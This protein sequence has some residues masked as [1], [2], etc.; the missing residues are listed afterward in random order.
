MIAAPTSL[1]TRGLAGGFLATAPGQ[2]L[3]GLL[4]DHARAR[5]WFRS[6]A[7]PVRGARI[8][9]LIA[10]DGPSLERAAQVVVLLEITYDGGDP[11]RDLYVL[12]LARVDMQAVEALQAEAPHAI[13]AALDAAAGG[14]ALVDGLATGQAAAG[15]LAVV[16]EG[17]TLRGQ[18]GE[19]AGEAGPL[20]AEVAG[21]PPLPVTVPR[22]EQTNSTLVFGNRVLLKI[23]R[24]LSGGVNPELEMGRYLTDHCRPPCTPRV[25]GALEYRAADGTRCGLGIAHEYVP[26]DG[27]AWTLALREARAYLEGPAVPPAT[28]GRLA[29]GAAT[30][31]RRTGQL[32]LALAGGT[33]PAF[34]PEP[35]SPADR[36]AL[37]ARASAML[38]ENLGS[39]QSLRD[40]LPVAA[41]TVADRLLGR[42]GREAIAA[43]LAHF[44]GGQSAPSKTRIHG[45]LHLG[46]VLVRGDDFMIIDFEGEPARPLPERRARS[47]PLRDVMGMAR[48]FDYAPQ[49]VMRDPSFPGPRPAREPAARRWTQQ[50]TAAYLRGYL[51]TVTGAPFIPPERDELGVLLTF[52]ELEKVIYEL[53]YEAN[54]RPDWVEI[55]LRG[56]AALAG[57][58][59]SG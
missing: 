24:Q 30:L 47:S 17:R 18:A 56:L 49:A 35:L 10:L 34:A 21:A 26:N 55:P 25:L 54:N 44:R 9:D 15:L 13:V 22:G 5:R 6:K 11:E 37:V 32:H 12:P 43:L 41:R 40:R 57:L 51:A 39:L 33:D 19:L 52:Y 38:D 1:D 2:R 48:S 31:G 59:P 8:A 20:F 28:V 14:G 16:R 4:L 7:R 58:E 36:V 29:A 45:D 53:G 23:Y 50:M 42:S 46:Q 3:A 27:D